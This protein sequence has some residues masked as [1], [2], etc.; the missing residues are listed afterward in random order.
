MT[1]AS[2]PAARPPSSRTRVTVASATSRAPAAVA[3]ARWTRIPDRFV[4][5]GQPNPQLPQSPQASALR[6]VGAASQPSARAPR[7]RIASLGGMWVDSATPSS[8]SMAATSSVP[9]VA[10]HPVQPVLGLPLRADVLGRGDA[11]RPVDERP[12]ADAGPGQHRDG[13]VPGRGQAV[14]QVVAVEAVELGPRHRRLVR[15]GAGFE[16]DDRPTGA[17]EC[18][19]DDPAAGPGPDDDRVGVE[20]DR[21]VGG[22]RT[23]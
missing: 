18:R 22:G 1:R 20:R 3:S 8:D 15:E 2:T 12:A 17:R 11:G 23:R 6:R 10:G 4:P 21:V 7:R 9:G 19:G 16:D 14:V 13:A 5:R